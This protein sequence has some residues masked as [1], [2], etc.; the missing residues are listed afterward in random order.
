MKVY[1]AVVNYLVGSG[2]RLFAGMVGSTSAPYVSALATQESARYIAVRHEQ[3]AAALLDGYGRLE[4]R[5]GCL[6]THGAAGVLAASLGIAAAAANSTPLLCLS[7]TQERV[8]MEQGFWQ[9]L[10]V[11]AP[12]SAIAKWQ[13]RVERPESAIS[14][15]RQALLEC[16]AGRPG[17]VQIDVPVDVATADYDGEPTKPELPGQAPVFRPAADP[18]VLQL[19]SDFIAA[20]ARPV[21]VAGGGARVSG[22]GPQLLTL[23][24][25]IGAP[26]ID[27]PTARG[28]VPETGDWCLGP[29]G[30]LGYEPAGR[31][32]MDADLILAVGS[33]LSDIQTARGTLLPASAPIVQVDIDPGAIG[34]YQ[35]VSAGIV[36]DARSF[37][38]QL[39]A[40]LDTHG[41]PGS[42][43][44]RGV[45]ARRCAEDARAWRQA[46]IAQGRTD[47]GRS[48]PVAQRGWLVQP[49]E[50]VQ[51]LIDDLPPT[52][53][54][55]HGAGDHGFY[56][57]LKPVAWPGTHLI[58]ARLGA[59]GCGLGYAL[60]ARLA[61][62]EQPVV[63]C[64]G[65]GELMLQVG[66]LETMVREQLNVVVVVFNNFRLGSQRKR[67]ELYGPVH[68]VDHTNPDFAELARLFGAQG[69]RVDR[70]GSFADALADALHCGAPAVIDVIIDPEA[71]PPRL[72]ISREARQERANA[73]LAKPTALGR[74]TLQ[75]RT[76]H[77]L[78]FPVTG[79][80]GS[81][82]AHS[83]QNPAANRCGR[84][85]L[86]CATRRGSVLKRQ[87]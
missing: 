30:I 59:M 78:A 4:R 15:V 32:L 25:Q 61:R 17:A 79:N 41:V 75:R 18:G 20:S 42:R 51:A 76:V 5:P 14:S 12:V 82:R 48:E 8:A 46:W 9:A 13:G 19:I 83:S 52:S 53:I 67:V 68:G 81:E 34:R 74:C 71:R 1:E 63:A 87:L 36:A 6:V 85:R 23:A 24:Q 33:R 72:Q 29:S 26:V 35:P 11:L 22:A 66:D 38:A 86:R 60:G 47:S 40:Y 77:R 49:Q 69:Y 39:S 73:D 43:E 57:L 45:W 84:H 31:A 2:V 44:A 62:P 7:A 70:P 65:D 16:L 58:S 50:V 3:V 28:V 37:A 64:L 56:G 55:A 80:P 21:L 27:S 54:L 10:S